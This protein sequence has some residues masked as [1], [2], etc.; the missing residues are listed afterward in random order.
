M[1][2]RTATIL[3]V[4]ATLLLGSPFHCDAQAAFDV[5]SIKPSQL[6]RTTGKGSR[7][8]RVFNTP[9]SL[10]LVNANLSDCMQRAYNV[11]FYQISGPPW[12]I[13]LRYDIVAKTEQ[14][15]GKEQLMAMLQALLADR[16]RLKLRRESRTEPIYALTARYAMKLKKS[17]S[18]D[19]AGMSLAGGSFVFKHVT[20]AE[21]AERLSDFSA[22]DR[23]VLDKTGIEG[24]YDI[25][26]ESA[27]RNML[28]DP[29][30]IFPSLE[31]AGFK[32]ESRKGQEEVLVVEHAEKPSAN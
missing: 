24:A 2:R 32:L 28:E 8:E 20:M 6:S 4:A 9:T 16:F 1:P 30:S 18:S 22:M 12:I 14:P 3:K 27:A 10:N 21:F 29:A 13:D 11:K 17:T 26:L 23:P 31:K 25:T 5:A 19:D 7:R 15:S